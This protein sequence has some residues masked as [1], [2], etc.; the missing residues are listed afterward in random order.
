MIHVFPLSVYYTVIT[1]FTK[2]RSKERTNPADISKIFLSLNPSPDM[3]LDDDGFHL[4]DNLRVLLPGQ[5]APRVGLQGKN[6]FLGSQKL[7]SFKINFY[8]TCQYIFTNI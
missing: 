6:R 7:K 4:T 3:L 5:I 2:K 1:Q 8:S